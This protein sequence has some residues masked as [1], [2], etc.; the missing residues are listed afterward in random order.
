M[1][2]NR[3]NRDQ[4]YAKVSALDAGQ[5]RKILWT[6]YWRGTA[7]ARERIEDALNPPA[8]LG[9]KAQDL[10]DPELLLGE[11]TEFVSL[12]RAGAYMY[13]DRRVSRTERTKW[14][15]TF[16]NLATQ[17]QSA[18]HAE[19]SGPA[20]QAMEQLIDLAC[21]MRDV[22]YFHSED[23]V[24]AARFVVSHAASALWHTVL[25][26]HGFAVF[27]G[28]A[29]PQLIRWESRYG[30]T[31]GDGKVAERETTLAEVLAPLLT[32]A[33]MWRGFAAVYLSALDAVARDETAATGKGSRR[34]IWVSSGRSNA[35][36]RR[37]DR[38]RTLAAWHAMLGEHLM[39]T[40]DAGLVDR[41][42]SHSALAGPDA[43]FLRAQLAGHSGDLGQA[44]K[45]IAECLEELP[46]S[47]EFHEFAAEI[48]A[49]LPPRAPASRR[50]VRRAADSLSAAY[51]QTDRVCSH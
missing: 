50:V 9:G 42:A 35:D 20:E 8:E 47:Q 36:Y 46:G 32:S 38:A 25:D 17:A 41:L 7:Q 33:D 15:V 30:W 6:L 51:N 49:D 31:R 11:V 44:R 26:Q 24:E 5:L 3:M 22:E 43:T 29:A 45:L 34:G 13:G 12:A 48:G 39:G 4:F 10:P 18:L 16:R 21:E 37:R 2:G 1:A 28:R 14:R 23:P 19:D 40:D 27:A